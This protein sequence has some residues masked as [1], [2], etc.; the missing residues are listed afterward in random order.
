M[1]TNNWEIGYWKG[2]KC[3]INF[4]TKLQMAIVWK[5]LEKIPDES[6]DVTFADPPFVYW[7]KNITAQKIVLSCK[8]IWIGVKNGWQ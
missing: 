2:K 1:V 7:R 3:L 8:Y 5:L 6:I 4:W